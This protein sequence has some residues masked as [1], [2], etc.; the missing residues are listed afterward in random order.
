MIDALLLR[1]DD[2][3]KLYNLE[4][5]QTHVNDIQLWLEEQLQREAEREP[6]TNEE[7][8]EKTIH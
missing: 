7:A 3:Q 2:I 1:E 5:V 4:A 6:I 8:D